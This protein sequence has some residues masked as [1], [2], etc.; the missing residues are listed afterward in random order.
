MVT[1]VPISEKS[2]RTFL[3]DCSCRKLFV[4]FPEVCDIGG[5]ASVHDSLERKGVSQDDPVFDI[6]VNL[7]AIMTLLTLH[8]NGVDS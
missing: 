7:V 1:G 4:P 2:A 5:P 8:A 3:A 6:T